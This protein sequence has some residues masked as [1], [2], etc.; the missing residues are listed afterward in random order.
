MADEILVPTD[1]SDGATAAL[2]HALDVAAADGA[3]V[4]VLFV[5]DTTGDGLRS[6][7]DEVLEVF[8]ARGAEIV[9][10]AAERANDRGVSVVDVVERGDPHETILT[11]AETAAVD[12]IT[13]GTHGRRGLKRLFLGSVTERVVRTATVPV[14]TVREPT[15]DAITFPYEDV[16]VA[17]DGSECATAALERG[18]ELAAERGATLHLLSVVDVPTT[19]AEVATGRLLEALE[20]DARATVETAADRAREVG[21]SS[22]VT[23]VE[24]GSVSRGITNYADEEGIDL[25]VVGT[26]ARRGVS[27]Y[28]MGSVAE[29]V[30]RTAPCPVVTV[31]TADADE[32]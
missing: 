23:A 26:H 31:R 21:V 12:L 28:V 4:H 19:G 30:V 29:L 16:L 1:G 27:R 10:A 22:V 3:R 7:D 17:T 25:A 6:D 14:L 9:T 2:E 18:A 11:Y 20:A 5:V 24:V 13:M 15:V 32:T 8:E